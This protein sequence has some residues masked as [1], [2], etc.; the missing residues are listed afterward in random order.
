MLLRALITTLR[1]L[2]ALIP[3][4]LRA[5]LACLLRTAL[6][7]DEATRFGRGWSPRG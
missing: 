3:L 4:L 2:G 6:L 1:L 7:L 5:L